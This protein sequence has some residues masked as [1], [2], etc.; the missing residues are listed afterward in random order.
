MT[1][2]DTQTDTD[3]DT[4]TAVVDAYVA[5]WNEADPATRTA[6]VEQAW[7]PEARYVDPLLDLTGHTDLATLK[8]L[9]DQHYPGHGIGRTTD[10]DTHH[11]VLR[12]GWELTAPD[13]AVVASGID[14]GVLADDGRL[15][16]IAGFFN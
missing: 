3:T 14:V 16:G 6:L 7:A 15:Q 5:S 10:V 13:G 11:N 12:F 8:P 4:V 9:L 1:N 2:T